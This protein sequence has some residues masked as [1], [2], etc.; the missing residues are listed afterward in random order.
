MRRRIQCYIYRFDAWLRPG[1]YQYC[2][3]CQ[4]WH[5]RL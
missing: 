3:H 1:F 4:D 5:V 2:L